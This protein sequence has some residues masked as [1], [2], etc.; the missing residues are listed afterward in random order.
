[1]L[2]EDGSI[3]LAIPRDRRGK[4]DPVIVPKGVTRVDGFDD[5][6][7]SLYARGLTVREITSHLYEICSVSVS[8]GLISQVTDAV[9]AVVK[10]WQSRPLDR[11]YPVVFLDALRVKI[12]DSGSVQN[13]AV[14]V[15]LALNADGKKEVLGLWIKQTEGA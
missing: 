8:P 1:V 14:Y 13:K 4:F 9:M 2:T 6:I 7:I 15:A 11:C 5:K 3:P 10:A 12:R